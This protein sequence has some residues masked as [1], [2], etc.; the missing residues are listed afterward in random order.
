M[1]ETKCAFEGYPYPCPYR[2]DEHGEGLPGGHTFAPAPRGEEK[3]CPTCGQSEPE[4]IWIE[5]SG[6]FE[7]HVAACRGKWKPAAPAPSA[8]EVVL[9]R[10]LTGPPGFIVGMDDLWEQCPG[11]DWHTACSDHTYEHATATIRR[12]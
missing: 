3:R 6:C 5:T 12:K 4:S 9:H 1:D 7:D 11:S 10:A 2:R 8:E